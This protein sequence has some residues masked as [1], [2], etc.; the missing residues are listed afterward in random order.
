MNNDRALTPTVARQLHRML[1]DLAQRED[2]LA[3]LESADVPYWGLCPPS[4]LGHRTA[5]DVLRSVAERFH[6]AC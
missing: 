2:E 4:V 3:L 1:L 5:A 6:S